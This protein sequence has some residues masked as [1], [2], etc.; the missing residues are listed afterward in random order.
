MVDTPREVA[1]AA[2]PGPPDMAAVLIGYRWARDTVGE[3]GGAIYRLHGKADAPD[4]YLKHG[5]GAVADDIGAE[6][7]RL[8]WVRR[9]VAVPAVV[10]F[11]RTPTE[12]WLL[13]TAMP[14]K[15]A[16]QLMEAHPER[17]GAIVDALA[18]LLRWLHAIP[19][20]ACPFNSDH[21]YRMYQAR[22][23]IDAGVVDE[24]DFDDERAG[25]TAPQ[26]WQAMQSLLPFAPDPVV[27]HGDFS[28]DNLF[29]EEG[30]ASGCIDAGR[31]G[32]AD[33]YQD[34]AILWHS[35]GE[36]GAALQERFLARYGIADLDVDK[37]QFHL[38][39]DEL[40]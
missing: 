19:V 8:H 10:H 36:Y 15:T 14:G 23:R 29:I 38:M 27:A 13:M 24:E 21:A 28:L 9:Y 34:V 22:V 18:V 25:W 1:C 5:V 26:V 16:Y 39:L 17:R 12:A 7:E 6:M 35:L 2:L 31:V 20:D 32:I 37:L 30:V 3:S 11:V 33:R 4:L 40:F